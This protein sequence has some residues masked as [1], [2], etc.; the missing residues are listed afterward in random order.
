MRRTGAKKLAELQKRRER[1]RQDFFEYQYEA[2]KGSFNEMRR[3]TETKNKKLLDLGCGYGGGSAYFAM[4]G[5]RV[6]AVDNQLYE[7]EF[8]IDA[9]KF[10]EKK[11]ALITICLADAHKLPF[12]EASF[13]IIRLDSVLEHLENPEKAVSECCRV[14][15]PEGLLFINFPLFYSPYGGHTIDYIKTP[16]YHILPDRW[17]RRAIRKKQ[18]KPGIIT[19]DYVE[20]LYMSLNKLTLKRYYKIIQKN[21]LE[22]I[23]SEKTAYMPHDAVL[24][25]NE[26]KS[27][28]SRKNLK[29]VKKTFLELN[30]AS[31]LIFI[32]LFFLYRFPFRSVN[33]INEVIV[34]GIRS[35]VK[36]RT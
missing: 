14:L 35:V 20:K 13:D 29:N 17:V 30:K 11:Q 10:A 32:F 27:S 9:I 4:H 6:T 3:F 16:W 34:S 21:N 23:Y 8:L 19:T 1:S 7:N 18:S 28:N 24:F 2:A 33:L 22:E 25:M 12:R 26:L 36:M 31:L 15:K 5:L